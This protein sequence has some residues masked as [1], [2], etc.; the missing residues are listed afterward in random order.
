MDIEKYQGMGVGILQILGRQRRN[1]A[2]RFQDTS[3]FI[4]DH[5]AN[6]FRKTFPQ[7]WSALEHG[8]SKFER[9]AF[10]R[11]MKMLQINAPTTH[12]SLQ[13]ACLA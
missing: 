10:E 12:L 3:Y 4:N 6:Q 11:A 13:M 7:I 5:H 9:T 1:L 8:V 2:N